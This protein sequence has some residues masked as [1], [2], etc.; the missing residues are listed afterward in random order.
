MTADRTSVMFVDDEQRVL[1]GLQRMLRPM[2]G[3]WDMVFVASGAAALEMLDRAPRDV[4][5]TDMRMPEM[6]GA[7][8]LAVVM[9]RWPACVRLILS[10]QADQ[11]MVRASVGLAHRLLDKPCD[12]KVLTAV[13]RRASALRNS[14]AVP[15]LRELAGRLG[16]LPNLPST[17]TQLVK[18]VNAP[19]GTVRQAGEIVGRDVG[20]TAKVMQIV[21]SPLFGLRRTVNDAVEAAMLIGVE[22]LTSLA[23][24]ARTFDDIALRGCAIPIDLLW[25]HS[26]QVADLARK[27]ATSERAPKQIGDQAFMSGMMHEVGRLVLAA[28][29]RDEYT[30]VMAVAGKDRAAI[31]ACERSTFAATHG[32]VSAYLLGLWGLPDS[33]VEA[34]LYHER[35]MQCPGIGAGMSVLMALHAAE[36]ILHSL[37][38]GRSGDALD[39]AWLRRSGFE[40]RVGAWVDIARASAPA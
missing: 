18:V 6:S 14:L 32:E 37:E 13:I 21:N 1:D 5:V 39:L 28:Y 12:A 3:E 34:T 31:E 20:M 29:A 40:A 2:R 4:V 30:R 9:L 23:L 10:G 19:N 25:R 27:I 22:T 36:G 38:S 24:S 33:V 16:T 15:R 8:L 11:E 7:E 35:P 17:Y 26:L